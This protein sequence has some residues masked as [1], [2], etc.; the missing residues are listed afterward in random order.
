MR[1][2]EPSRPYWEYR[3][4]DSAVP[5]PEH[6]AWD[7]LILPADDPWW[8]THYPPNGWGCKCKVFALSARDLKRMGKSGP[9]TAPDNG[10]Y[11]WTDKKTG[12]THTVP[13]GIDPGWDYNV[14]E[15]AWGRR[16]AD[17]TMNAWR[18]QGADAW[19]RLTPG[20]WMSAGRPEKIAVD[21]PLARAGKT[22][23]SKNALKTEL[24]WA[25][26]GEEKI[27]SYESGA[28][29]YDILAN[30]NTLSEHLPL[31]RAP[32]VPLI[33]EALADPFEVWLSFERHKGTG[34]Y[35]IRQRIIKALRLD[36]DRAA[37]MVAQSNGGVME[38]W[39]MIPTSKLSYV[40][41]HRQGKL[42]WAR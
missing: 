23:T 17:D 41:N 12:E 33:P 9:D 22:V 2:D 3:H 37:L 6:L 36:K 13:K 35:E 5:R 38:A 39:T 7:G 15:A 20:D 29:R 30:A 32:F 8:Q 42:I 18:A 16:L 21:K 19:Q 40:N 27:F 11:Q 34:R 25:L 24:A 10:T 31:D 26:G 4:G 1:G 14:G 28:F